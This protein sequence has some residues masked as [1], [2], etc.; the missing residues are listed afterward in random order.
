MSDDPPRVPWVDK[1]VIV[2]YSAIHGRGL[3][4]STNLDTGHVVVRLG[5][6]LASSSELERLLDE[7]AAYV[8]T[9]AVYEDVHLVLP[10]GTT[11]H[12]GNHSCDP[13]AW[14]VGPYEI[15]TRRP[16]RAGEE[17]TVDYGTHSGGTGFS[18]A[19]SCGA[20]NC[21][22]R[23]TSDDWRRPELQRIYEGHWVPVLEERIRRLSG[24]SPGA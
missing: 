15:A 24:G 10:S 18:M 2:D 5:G 3:F 4:T 16:V 21:R 11:V 23:V 22:G 9:V 20:T 13:N 8:D 6:R 12:Y 19:C 7:S 14:H 17:L 1:A